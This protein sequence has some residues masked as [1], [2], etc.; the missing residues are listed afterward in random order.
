MCHLQAL[1][2]PWIP[3]CSKNCW[4]VRREEKE[5]H[6]RFRLGIPTVWICWAGK[7]GTVQETWVLH[8]I[9]WQFLFQCFYFMIS[10][11]RSRDHTW[12]YDH[13]YFGCYVNHI[14]VEQI[15]LPTLLHEASLE[16]CKSWSHDCRTL[17]PSW[18]WS[19][20]QV[21]ESWLLFHG[22]AATV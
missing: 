21:P 14:I 6:Q 9:T 12:F 13:V 8:F 17:Q 7:E 4:S 5:F 3:Y 10:K 11:T 19:D 18:M 16:G 1:W 15:W 22:G 2:R 20:C